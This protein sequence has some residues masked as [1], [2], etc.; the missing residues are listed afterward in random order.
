VDDLISKAQRH[1]RPQRPIPEAQ[2]PRPAIGQAITDMAA[3]VRIENYQEV[4]AVMII[5]YAKEKTEISSSAFCPH[6]CFDR[7]RHGRRQAGGIWWERS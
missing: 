6:R 3:K 4:N 1:S 2:P 7:R 5:E